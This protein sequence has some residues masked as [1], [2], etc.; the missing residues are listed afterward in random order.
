M[1]PVELAWADSVVV[2]F[3]AS[4]S[5][6]R[7]LDAGAEAAML[8]SATLVVLQLTAR[9][10][11]WDDRPGELSGR[12]THQGHPDVAARIR[13]DALARLAERFPGLAFVVVRAGR[14]D[15]DVVR[16]LGQVAQLLVLGQH[17]ADGQR[18][19]SMGST[20]AEIARAFSC[21][22]L[23]VHDRYQCPTETDTDTGEWGRVVAG[24]DGHGDSK[25]VLTAAGR[26]AALRSQPLVVVHSSRSGHGRDHVTANVWSAL[27][28]VRC[29]V[30]ASSVRHTV[31][32][33]DEDPVPALVDHVSSL[34]LIVV[35]TRGA[36]RL[37]GL[38]QGSTSRAVLGAA[39]CDVLVV[40]ALA[41]SSARPRLR[42]GSDSPRRAGPLAL[43]LAAPSAQAG[44]RRQPKGVRT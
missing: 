4:R 23:L 7:A 35:G 44:V 5:S 22:L 43:P 40:Q 33:S 42:T 36:G 37:S 29:T 28:S 32:V 9:T 24:V 6:R 41:D 20:S 34:D 3:D 18:C 17:G 39:P 15:A 11:T 1:L 31:I 2:G 27:R 13:D 16:T 12:R 30:E 25:A 19:L 21:P 38:V 10:P 14:A 8:R 26:E